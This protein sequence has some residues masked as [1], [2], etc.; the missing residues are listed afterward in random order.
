MAPYLG[1]YS[2]EDSD[3]EDGR[4]SPTSSPCELTYNNLFERIHCSTKQAKELVETQKIS[5]STKTRTINRHWPRDPVGKPI[6]PEN[7]LEGKQAP[8]GQPLWGETML[9]FYRVQCSPSNPELENSSTISTG[10]RLAMWMKEHG[11]LQWA[12]DELERAETEGDPQ[13]IRPWH[14]SNVVEEQ[15]QKIRSKACGWGKSM[16]NNGGQ[17]KNTGLFKPSN[18]PAPWPLVPFSYPT[19]RLQHRIEHRELPQKLIVHDPWQL[20]AITRSPEGTNVNVPWAD[21][22]DITMTYRLELSGKSKSPLKAEE[23]SS[24]ECDSDF[25]GILLDSLTA[26]SNP[27]SPPIY[28]VHPPPPPSPPVIEAHIYLS[29]AHSAGRGTHSRVYH[30]ELELPRDAVTCFVMCKECIREDIAAKLKEEDDD[31]GERMDEKWKIKSTTV[32]TVNNTKR[33]VGVLAVKSNTDST[34][35]Q[36]AAEHIYSHIIQPVPATSRVQL[37]GAIRPIQT[38]VTWRNVSHPAV[39]NH[40]QSTAGNTPAETKLHPPTTKVRVVA[41]ISTQDDAHLLNEARNYQDFAS[42]LFEHSTGFNAVPPL[43][44][45]VPVGAVV[46]QFYGYYVPESNDKEGGRSGAD[47][48]QVF[49]RPILLLEDCGT[50]VN[51]DDLNIDDR[52]VPPPH[53]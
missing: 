28:V 2:G 15:E 41:K 48:D 27:I 12:V 47:G 11:E 31:N 34:S 13:Q 14:V 25:D 26:S 53:F 29:P 35:S 3:E 1:K 4:N 10:S 42:H 30:A 21:M 49:Q 9:D 6:T 17:E 16:L 50:P 40:P 39:C 7:S 8:N 37:V 52:S 51:T 46:P 36:K 22:P 24:R 19:E 45:P 5:K 38:S 33:G 44:D 43:H 32:E 18:Y 23:K 20:L